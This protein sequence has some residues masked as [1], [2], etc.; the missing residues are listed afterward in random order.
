MES[1]ILIALFLPLA[2]FTIMLGMGLGRTP[3]DFKRILVDPKGGILGLIVQ[4]MMLPVVGLILAGLFPLHPEL[5]VG[6]IILAACSGGPTSNLMTYLAKGN[7]ALS[8]TLTAI[9]SLITVFT[10][11]LIVNGAMQLFL[12]EATTLQLPF[13]QTVL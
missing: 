12:G 3:D 11:P 2:L 4:L 7:V 10:I 9:S 8:I 1:N 13:L 5:A 6:V